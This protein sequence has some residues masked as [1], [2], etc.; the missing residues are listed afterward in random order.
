M[1]RGQVTASSA[2]RGRRPAA[3]LA[4][5]LLCASP[6]AARAAPTEDT[7]RLLA[8]L[9]HG[10]LFGTGMGRL[11]GS[12]RGWKSTGTRRLMVF[13]E[14]AVGATSY[15]R[16]P[17]DALKKHLAV[18]KGAFEKPPPFH[19]ALKLP[20]VFLQ[21]PPPPPPREWLLSE[22]DAP[23]LGIDLPAD[24][25][26]PEGKFIHEDLTITDVRAALETL[27]PGLGKPEAV[28]HQV[29]SNGFERRPTV[30]T[31][32]RYARGAVSFATSNY[33]PAAGRI[34]RVILDVPT[35][36]AQLFEPDSP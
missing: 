12:L 8:I 18:L 6:V 34:D 26:T 27:Q 14:R 9:S 15:A 30:L 24:L 11:L 21:N 10:K 1:G 16:L 31:L 25:A 28:E 35:I 20:K 5:V 23:H 4:A 17:P 36:H 7:A 19:K 32:H 29:I 33:A 22:D 13:P 3:W 2:H